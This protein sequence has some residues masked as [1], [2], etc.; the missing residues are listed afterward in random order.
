MGIRKLF[1]SVGLCAFFSLKKCL[2]LAVLNNLHHSAY[3]FQ[4]EVLIVP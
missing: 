4:P 2:L 1:H 3:S